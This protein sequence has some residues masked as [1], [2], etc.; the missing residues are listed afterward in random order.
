MSGINAGRARVR[1]VGLCAGVTLAAFPCARAAENSTV[2]AADM[3]VVTATRQQSKLINQV[4]NESVI[5]RR[6]IVFTAPER[7]SEILNQL[8]GVN[9]QQ[10]SGEEHLTAIRSPVLNAGA[11][12]GSFLYLEDGVPLRA[13]G[14]GN[15]NGLYEADI[16]QAGSV[17]VIRGPGSALYGS[18]AEDG[19]INVIPLAPT[20]KPSGSLYVEAGSYGQR[21]TMASYS[22]A[23]G[24]NDFRVS[25]EGVHDAGWRQ[26]TGITEG[27][28]ELRDV[29]QGG[30]STVTSTLSGQTLDQRSGAY[31][32]G[33][34]AYDNWASAR[35]NP[36]PQAYRKAASIRGQSRWDD[37]LGDD[38]KLSLTPYF[39]TTG[40]GFLMSYLPS[41]AIQKNA[42]TSGGLQSA[43]YKTLSGGHKI[44]FG[45]DSEYTDGW[46]TEFQNRPSFKMSGAVSAFGE[47]YNFGV[48]DKVL[49]PYVHSEWHVSPSTRIIAGVRLEQTWYDYSNHMS[50]GIFGLYQ[51][52]PNRSDQFTT[53]MPKLGVVQ[54]L[55]PN[56]SAYFN[57]SRGSRAPQITDM[58]ELQYK[59]TIG[60]I[61][62][63]S[64]DS[65]ELGM[66]GRISDVSFDSSVYWMKKNHYFYRA[67][68]GTNV[69]NGI[70]LDRGVELSIDAPLPGGFDV[71]TA[72]TYAEHTYDFNRPDS[73]LINSVYKGG[74]IPE[75]P[76]TIAN[77]H[78]GYYFAAH[79]RA[80]IEWVHMGAYFLDNADTHSYGGYELFNL[81]AS[82]QVTDGGLSVSGKIL[83][84][85]NRHYAERAAVT[86][87]GVD[88]YFPGAPLTFY[89]G[90]EQVF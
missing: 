6:D 54:S 86:P 23:V 83:N 81:R 82:S 69:S 71:G 61:K 88:E 41:L 48:V 53:V 78:F 35:R 52:V 75:A 39:R 51:R 70:T 90:V 17:E 15:V 80:Q 57:L 50:S 73:I 21:R 36:V 8:A 77:T 37:N 63:E 47:H 32:I 55:N 27:K 34:D 64:L 25:A 74:Y 44:I 49:A 67:S 79:T 3:V 29:W 5:D 18:N 16:E 84:L 31:I 28:F 1:V 10:G 7:P 22:Q 40:M 13:A 20:V 87:T 30:N 12:A 4:S 33:Y 43:L 14:F 56:I 59:Q 46:Y 58:Y 62:P 2:A 24:A 72:A 89:L 76:R 68:D 38:W 19:M 85:L 66:R 26:D 11:G 45:L 65:A 42:H 60:Q 9:I